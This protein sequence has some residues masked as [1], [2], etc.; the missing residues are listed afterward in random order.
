MENSWRRRGAKPGASSTRDVTTTTAKPRAHEVTEQANHDSAF[1]FALSLLGGC[2]GGSRLVGAGRVG[3]DSNVTRLLAGR[4]EAAIAA[5][6]RD[7]RLK[8]VTSPNLRV[9]SRQVCVDM[10]KRRAIGA[11]RGAAPYPG[12]TARAGMEPEVSE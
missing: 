12:A 11:D 3:D 5:L 6:N 1:R 4:F 7:S 2:V 10:L 8:V 9:R